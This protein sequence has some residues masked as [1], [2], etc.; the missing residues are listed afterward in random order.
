MK[1]LFHL[2]YHVTDLDAARRFYGGV[3]GC[4]E[5][6]STDT[7]RR[8]FEPNPDVRFPKVNWEAT[9]RRVLALEEFRGV[10]LSNLQPGDLTP[11]QRTAVV[12]YGA[13]AVARQCL[14]IGL[15]HADPHPGNLFALP[16]EGGSVAAGF[17]D[18]GM[19][20]RIEPMHARVI[21]PRVVGPG[22]RL[23]IPA[24]LP[25]G[26]EN[27]HGQQRRQPDAQHVARRCQK[28]NKRTN[29]RGQAGLRQLEPQDA[30]IAFRGN[31]PAKRA[32]SE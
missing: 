1:A 2:A 19:T 27:S 18:C 13:D 24:P 17:I 4:R 25:K 22:Q 23:L 10:L 29:D 20:G 5:G 16:R 32:H 15:F 14:E 21:E 3:L 11:Q 31:S 7:L 28:Q 30:R 12:A 9:T 26:H 8:A 6:R